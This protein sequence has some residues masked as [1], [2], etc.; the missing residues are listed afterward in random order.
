MDHPS[1]RYRVIWPENHA[2][3]PLHMSTTAKIL[4][5]PAT[6]K[7]LRSA[8]AGRLAYVL[9]GIVGDEEVDLCVQVNVPLMGAPPSVAQAMSTK[10]GA[11]ALLSDAGVIVPQ[12]LTL[13]PRH[14]AGT[15]QQSQGWQEAQG[16]AGPTALRANTEFSIGP[17][18]EVNVYEVSWEQPASHSCGCARQ[19]V[20]AG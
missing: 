1:S 10:S 15:Q 13:L 16:Q 12:G 18:G 6:M 19:P 3:L 9:P 4:S 14:L 20:D 2:R 7:R 17:D 8:V 11:R 5:S